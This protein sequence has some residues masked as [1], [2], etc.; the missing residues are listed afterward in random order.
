MNA[1]LLAGA[2]LVASICAGSAMAGDKAPRLSDAEYVAAAR[3]TAIAEVRGTSDA[4]SWAEAMQEQNRGRDPV[5]RGMADNARRDVA[6]SARQAEAG[7]TR[8]TA[9]IARISATCTETLAKA[10]TAAPAAS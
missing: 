10:T 9:E 2:A 4:A 3:C 7:S 5:V 6:R 1:R 8:A